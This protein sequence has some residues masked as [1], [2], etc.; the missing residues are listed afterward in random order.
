MR[1]LVFAFFL[2]FSGLVY[3]Q[4]KVYVGKNKFPNDQIYELKNNIV[5]RLSN[6]AIRSEYLF[7]DGEKVYFRDRKSFTDIKYTV[8][9]NVIYKANST[10][11][12]DVLFTLKEGKLYIGNSTFSTDCLF[13]FKD[14]VVYRG[15]STSTFD[16]FMTYDLSST[17]DLIWIAVMIAPY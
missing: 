15:D 7:I 4:T 1:N 13:T 12:F 2:L 16:A 6:S 3:S 11:T 17:D 14:G 10:S 8:K 9:S 5:Y